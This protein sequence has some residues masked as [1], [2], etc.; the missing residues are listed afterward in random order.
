MDIGH[1]NFIINPPVGGGMTNPTLHYLLRALGFTS[2]GPE[3]IAPL[4]Q[5]STVPIVSEAN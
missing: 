4:F 3:P 2:R 1:F 5:Y